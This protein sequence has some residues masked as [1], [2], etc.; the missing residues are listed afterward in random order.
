MCVLSIKVPKRKKSGNL[1]YA[2]RI[3]NR[4]ASVYYEEK[5]MER[6][7]DKKGNKFIKFSVSFVHNFRKTLNV[8]SF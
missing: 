6:L 2:P 1:S 8:L 4:I 7:G 5:N 3:G